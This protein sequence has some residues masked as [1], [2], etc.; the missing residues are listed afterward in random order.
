VAAPGLE[1]VG[2]DRRR[3]FADGGIPTGAVAVGIAD[4]EIGRGVEI[5]ARVERF[6]R[7]GLAD[8]NTSAGFIAEAAESGRDFALQGGS[9]SAGLD[10]AL[11]LAAF[12]I[13]IDA[14]EAESVGAGAR[15]IDFL[16]IF[17]LAGS[18]GLK[19]E[20][21]VLEQPGVEVDT[22]FETGETMIAED[23][24]DG[25]VVDV[26]EGLADESIGAH[27]EIFDR[28]AV[29]TA[30]I[31]LGEEH[32][33]HPIGGIEDAGHHSA[34]RAIER[35]QELGLAFFVDEVGLFEKGG[36]IDGVFVE[37]PGVLRDR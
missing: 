6:A 22:A 12:L 29:G 31:F 7:P 33:L 32:V 23:E 36:V 26:R 11:G 27:V 21:A 14:G 35:A 37:S 8:G 15:P 34:A 4:D 10:S 16:E 17:S 13:N 20:I 30:A 18:A 9:W 3:D 28:T 19:S 25:L 2:E 5:G 24:Q 1:I